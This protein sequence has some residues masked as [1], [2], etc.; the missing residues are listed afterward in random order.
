MVAK[1][2]PKKE[3][4]VK[5]EP[6]K[7]VC[8][9]CKLAKWVTDNHRHMDMNGKPICLTCPNKSYYIVRGTPACKDFK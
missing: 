9:D 2:P 4:K 5:K 8:D 3:T 1:R 7:H 6:E